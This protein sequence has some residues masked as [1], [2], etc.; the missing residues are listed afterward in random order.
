MG[1]LT[2]AYQ[3]ISYEVSSASISLHG[4]EIFFVLDASG[5]LGQLGSPDFRKN[6]RKIRQGKT[7]YI[8]LNKIM[9]HNL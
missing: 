9:D 6:L 1:S 5:T 7:I 4:V 3:T 8:S 2:W